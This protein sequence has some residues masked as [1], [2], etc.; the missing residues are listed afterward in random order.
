MR[1]RPAVCTIKSA[2]LVHKL[3]FTRT[4]LLGEEWF[5]RT[6]EAQ[7]GVPAFFRVSLNPVAGLDA[8]GLFRG[9]VD[10]RGAVGVGFGGGRRIAGC[11]RAGRAAA[12]RGAQTLLCFLNETIMLVWNL[13]QSVF[14]SV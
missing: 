13:L 14:E 4:P 8:V 7:E 10:R 11:R 6:V 5:Q 9:E 3:D 1:K 2:E 12:W